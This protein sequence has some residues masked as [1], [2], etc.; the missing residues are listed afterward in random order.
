MKC[1]MSKKFIEKMIETVDKHLS[2]D[3]RCDIEKIPET[4][5]PGVFVAPRIAQDKFINN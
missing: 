1:I 5:S 2:F 3:V 4:I